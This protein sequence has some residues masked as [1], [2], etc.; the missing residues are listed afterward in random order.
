M[1]SLSSPLQTAQDST[2]RK[3]YVEATVTDDALHFASFKTAALGAGTAASREDHYTSA[4]G[5]ILSV[6]ATKPTSTTLDIWVRRVTAPETLTQ[7]DSWVRVVTAAVL[8]SNSTVGL[9]MSGN[10]ANVYIFYHIMTSASTD[11]VWMLSSA[12]NGST[13]GS[14]AMQFQNFDALGRFNGLNQ[15]IASWSNDFIIFLD[16]KAGAGRTLKIAR[17][18]GSWTQTDVPFVPSLYTFFDVE[19]VGIYYRIFMLNTTTPAPLGILTTTYDGNNWLPV[20]TLVIN[21]TNQ[22]QFG[23]SLHYIGNTYYSIGY[24][25]IGNLTGSHPLLKSSD[26]IHWR[27]NPLFAAASSIPEHFFKL[28]QSTNWYVVS[29]KYIYKAVGPA[30]SLTIGPDIETYQAQPHPDFPES[31]AIAIQVANE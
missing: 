23:H 26:F 30:T 24:L 16:D 3:S 31:E 22:S 12:N 1:R 25:Q 18:S 9:S 13:W 2:P 27:T 6:W 11:E 4:D 5:S 8:D 15:H 29:S 10:G 20:E 7:W 21:D 28:F 17:Y 19:K 14:A